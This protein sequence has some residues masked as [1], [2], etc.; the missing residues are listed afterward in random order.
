MPA[1]LIAFI[2]AVILMISRLSVYPA[3]GEV[4]PVK[5]AVVDTG[6]NTNRLDGARIFEGKNYIIADG[7]TQDL[8]GHGTRI[9]SII[10]GADNGKIKLTGSAPKAYLVPL[11]YASKLLSGVPVRGGADMIAQCIRDA[12]DIYDCRV[13]CVSSGIVYDDVILREAVL[14]AEKK[15]AVVVSAAGNDN[16]R[17][18]ERIYYPAEYQTVISVGSVNAD[19]EISSFSQRSGKVDL[20]A[21]GEDVSAVSVKNAK[22]YETVSGTSYAAAYIAGKAAN[23][24]M[25]NPGI[26]PAEVR[27]ILYKNVELL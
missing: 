22:F 14:Y 25:K 18:P 21:L 9:A 17:A 24:F 16:I 7:S 11:V 3:V 10:L 4:S 5:I 27:D 6:I 19:G 26:T 23:L 8:D 2:I 12:V 15:G 20:Y 1:R 13:I